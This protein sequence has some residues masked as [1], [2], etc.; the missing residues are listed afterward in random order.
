M[1]SEPNAPEES[2]SSKA[3]VVL[4]VVVLILVLFVGYAL[5]FKRGERTSFDLNSGRE[6]TTQ[7]VWFYDYKTT[8]QESIFCKRVKERGLANNEPRWVDESGKIGAKKVEYQYNGAND[9]AQNAEVFLETFRLDEASER[10]FLALILGYLA[11]PD[12]YLLAHE[13]L[14]GTMKQDAALRNRDLADEESR[15]VIADLR[16]EIERLENGGLAELKEKA[17][18]FWRRVE[19]TNQHMLEHAHGHDHDEHAHDDHDHDHDHAHDDHEHDHEHD[20]AHDGHDHDHDAD[21]A[22]DNHDHDH[23]TDHDHAHGDHDHNH[24][25]DVPESSL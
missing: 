12:L 25:D 11:E 24:A 19:E 16:K 17:E 3:I 6:K 20:H 14:T 18:E 9:V 4:F 8:V 2:K 22:H 21:H 23:E 10:E 13:A 5:M 7:F 1:T 15:R